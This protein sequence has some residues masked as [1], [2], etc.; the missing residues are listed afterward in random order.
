[1]QLSIFRLFSLVIIQLSLLKVHPISYGLFAMHGSYSQLFIS[2]ESFYSNWVV[3][4]IK[5]SNLS[6]SKS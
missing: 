3:L 5:T 1:M 2:F 6:Y 4:E